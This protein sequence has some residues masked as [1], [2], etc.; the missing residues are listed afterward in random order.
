MDVRRHDLANGR[1]KDISGNNSH[2]QLGDGSTASLM[3][4]K[5]PSRGYKFDGIDDYISLS[6]P[7]GDF[8]ISYLIRQSGT[9][10][11]I[12]ENDL[13]LLTTLKTSGGFIGDLLSIRIH[14]SLLTDMQMANEKALLLDRA[15]V[16]GVPNG[17]IA[18]L[19]SE[20][21]LELYHDYRYGTFSD[22][23]KSNHGI[24]T[25]TCA[26][27]GQAITFPAA[28]AHIDTPDITMG[29]EGSIVVLG[30]FSSV[31]ATKTLLMQGA[32]FQEDLGIKITATPSL[33]LFNG[34][35]S[36]TLNYSFDGS[37]CIAMNFGNGEKA[38]FFLDG[39][40]AGLVGSATTHAANT[41]PFVIG[42]TVSGFA[43]EN[44]PRPMKA[45]LILSRK[46]SAIEHANL[47]EELHNPAIEQ[48]LQEFSSVDLGEVVDVRDSSLVCAYGSRQISNKLYNLKDSSYT[49]TLNGQTKSA[50]LIDS[51]YTHGR[52]SVST[53]VDNTILNPTNQSHTVSCWFMLSQYITMGVVC[54][55]EIAGGLGTTMN[56]GIRLTTGGPAGSFRC[57]YSHYTTT[58]ANVSSPTDLFPNQWIHA[59]YATDYSNNLVSFYLN[60][61]LVGTVA[62]GSMYAS[63]VG[64][65][66][67]FGVNGTISPVQDLERLHIG[68]FQ[69][70]NMAKDQTWITRE[71]QKGKAALGR[72]GYGIKES[73]SN[74]T[75]S[76][77][78]PDS[79]IT[80]IRGEVSLRTSEINGIKAKSIKAVS[81]SAISID[82]RRVR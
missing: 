44:F 25:S 5:L 35:F 10:E 75:A 2:I 37:K 15:N 29:L 47:F 28:A 32:G 54:G 82:M 1:T 3:P 11:V 65:F 80:V 42:D 67:F 69:I 57:L 22:F 39:I 8:T 12:H 52:A 76:V 73:I 45:V 4:S 59:C 53:G 50:G 68:Q 81:D 72:L 24:P 40:S 58:H 46:L 30:D 43:G 34:G 18:K 7:T 21:V 13:T 23:S 62:I 20:G 31:G 70:H 61:I 41:R 63:P 38:E 9:L 55:K 74:A 49:V 56:G 79:S 17:Q 60:G 16:N 71:Y 14:P 6:D 33:Q 66:R 51:L 27:S 64:S 36:E 19:I 78:L 77:A 48:S 26:W